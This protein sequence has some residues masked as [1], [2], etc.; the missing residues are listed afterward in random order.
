[1]RTTQ[2]A[3]RKSP[4]RWLADFVSRLRREDLAAATVRGYRYDLHQ[5]LRW[6]N[7]AKRPA[8]CE[9]LSALDLINYR[10]HLVKVEGLRPATVKPPTRDAPAVLSLGPAVQT[11]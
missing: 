3:E 1:L 9:K 8:R 2:P 11:S 5:F 7:R 10:Q 4:D 6:F